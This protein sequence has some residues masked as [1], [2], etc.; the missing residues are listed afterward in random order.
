MSLTFSRK[1]RGLPIVTRAWAEA[2]ILAA[3]VLASAAFNLALRLNPDVAWLYVIAKKC[4]G[5]AVLYKDII[6]VNAPFASISLMPPVILQNATSLSVA[7]S[8]AL[9][10]LLLCLLSTLACFRLIARYVAAES[11]LDVLKVSVFIAIFLLPGIAFGEREHLF[12]ILALP[13]ILAVPLR[14]SDRRPGRFAGFALAFVAGIACNLKPP[15]A[16]IILAVEIA[17]LATMGVRSLFTAAM[18]GLAASAILSIA[19][20]GFFF[21]LYLTDVIPW[22]LA[23]YHGYNDTATTWREAVL[24]GGTAAAMALVWRGPRVPQ[25]GD[26]PAPTAHRLKHVL[27]AVSA[28]SLL[29]FLV[30]DKGWDYQAFVVAFCTVIMACM[31]L[32]ASIRRPVTRAVPAL[33]ILVLLVRGFVQFKTPDYVDYHFPDVKRL[34][35]ASPGRFLILTTAGTPA[36]RHIIETGHDWAS[37][38]PCMEM[39]PGIVAASSAGLVSPYEGPFRAAMAEDLSRFRPPL[40]FVQLDDLPGLPA[41]FDLLGWLMR[42]PRFAAQWSHYRADGGADGHFAVYRRI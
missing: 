2:I 31:A 10:V 32:Q 26:Q 27:V 1:P 20:Y 17:S 6:A 16:A 22:T 28:S 4:L 39:L 42:D 7:A 5:G 34:V 38:Y 35:A 19:A 41:T 25:F 13:Y 33:V 15:F 29:V 11:S 24:W 12:C 21:P 18:P 40:I 9:Y 14:M 36:G 3:G 8:V 37:R 30:Q 23:L